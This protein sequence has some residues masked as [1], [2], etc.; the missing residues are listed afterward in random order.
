MA[1]VDGAFGLK[2]LRHLFGGEVRLN[3]YTIADGYNTTIYNGDLVSTTG[4]GR[5]ISLAGVA[6]TVRGVFHGCNYVNAQGEPVFS[7]YWPASTDVI[8]TVEALV[9]D[10]PNILFEVQADEDIVADD[11]GQYADTINHTSGSTRTGNSLRELDSSDIN[12]S[13]GQLYIYELINRPD[14]A[15]GDQAKVAVLIKLH[16]LRT[17]TAT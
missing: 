16:E 15:Y 1:N 13:D 6:D 4:T 2:P 9:Y 8:G 12:G 11:I 3:S 17:P 14:N 5:N 10:D 7:P